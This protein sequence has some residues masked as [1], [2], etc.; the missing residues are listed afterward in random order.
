[1][2]FVSGNRGLKSYYTLLFFPFKLV[3]PIRNSEVCYDLKINK[4]IFQSADYNF[5]L[6]GNKITLRTND[7]F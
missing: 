7:Y 3:F 4:N 1:M 5:L 2:T 6:Y